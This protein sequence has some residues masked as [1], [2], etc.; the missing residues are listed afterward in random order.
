MFNAQLDEVFASVQGEGPY[1]GQRHIFVRFSG[2]GLSCRYCDTPASRIPA[3]GEARECRVQRSARDRAREMVDNP[4]RG[5]V[6]SGF[7]S[8]L[9]VP[10]PGR[11]VISLTG[12]EPLLQAG[13]L[14]EWLPGMGRRHVL[15]LETCGIHSDEMLLLRD[16]IDVISMDVKLPSA[17]GMAP[18]W[19]E[20][21]RF[22]AAALGRV[23]FVKAVVTGDTKVDDVRTAASIVH[24]ADRTVPLIIQPASGPLAPLP[25]DLLIF[26][27]AALGMLEDVRIIP[28]VHLSLGLP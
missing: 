28:Q 1:V 11:P 19:E 5:D 21:R 4:V 26:Q 13:F 8:R 10:G 25:D 15:Y 22:L 23:V 14:R 24:A 6:L 2:C 9:A 17:S 12:G 7:C 27:E 3:A 18:L 20:H 16:H